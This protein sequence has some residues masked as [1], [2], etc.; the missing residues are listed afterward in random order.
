MVWL[1]QVR[2]VVGEGDVGD[3]FVVGH[4]L[5]DDFLLFAG[6]RARPNTVRAYAHDLK[7]FFSVVAR[8]RST[9]ALR[10]C[11]GSSPRSSRR[12]SARRTWHG[13]PTAG[14]DCRRRRCAAGWLRCRRSMAI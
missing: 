3:V 10:T 1:P 13:S 8:T 4:R 2:R 7:T 11:S 5:V 14:R 6:G 12:V 9:Y